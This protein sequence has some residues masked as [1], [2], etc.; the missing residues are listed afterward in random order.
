MAEALKLT[1]AFG[2]NKD[3]PLAVINLCDGSKRCIF[4]ASGNTGVVFDYA[5]GHQVLLRGHRNPISCI[6]AS[7]DRRWLVTADSGKDSL[8]I[9]WDAASGIAVKTISNP[10]VRGVAAVDIS[11]D[12]MLLATLSVELPQV[13][14]VWEW[15]LDN[16]RPLSHSTRIPS[17]DTQISLRFHPGD[18]RHILTNGSKRVFFWSIA[19][20][21]R[22]LSFFSPP[23]STR[24]FKQSVGR[25]T[26]SV[27]V[28]KTDCAVTGTTEGDL[29]L[30]DRIEKKAIKVVRVHNSTVEVVEVIGKHIVTGGADGLIRF[31]DFNF[32]IMAWFE[33]LNAG[34]VKGISFHAFQ[35]AEA[36]EDPSDVFRMR[37]YS[38]DFIVNTD[39][40]LV[41]D[42]ESSLFEE[43]DP[44]KRRGV[45][46]L[47]GQ[48]T[49]VSSLS[50]HPELPVLAVGSVAGQLHLWNYAVKKLLLV[51]IFQRM[52]IC[53]LAYDQVEG[54]YLVVAFD[55]GMI[56]ILDGNTLEELITFEHSRS[57]IRDIVF[58]RDATYFATSDDEHCVGIYKW[59]HRDE[60]PSKPIEWTF[61]GRYK[62]HLKRISGLAFG[63][64]HHLI[65]CAEDRRLVEYSVDTS[66]MRE[67]V[68]LQSAQKIE[69]SL[70]PTAMF[71]DDVEGKLIFATDQGK[72]RLYNAQ[73]LVCEKTVLAPSFGPGQ[74]HFIRHLGVHGPESNRYVAYAMKENVI[75]ICKL[76]LDGNPYKSM[77]VIAHPGPIH[78]LS[79]S[80]DGRFAFSTGGKDSSVLM[81]TVQAGKLDEFERHHGTSGKAGSKVEPYLSLIPGGADSFIYKDFTDYFY[82]AQIRTQGEA[83]TSPRKIVGYIPFE[84]V[85]NVM[86]AVGFF[87]SERAVLDMYNELERSPDLARPGW[88]DFDTSFLLYVNHRP[89]RGITSSDI[90]RAFKVVGAQVQD[91]ALPRPVF[92]DVMRHRGEPV[93]GEEM[94]Q[95]VLSL[96]GTTEGEQ[97]LPLQLTVRYLAGELLQF[98]DFVEDA[99]AGTGAGVDENADPSLS[100]A[101]RQDGDIDDND[102]DDLSVAFTD[103]TISGEA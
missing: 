35:D 70:I 47:Q 33:D 3:L 36:E 31:Y 57:R 12:S 45:L 101:N 9:V 100:N 87:P 37:F 24:E 86:R 88:V 94:S 78:N 66:S 96:L 43:V 103:G 19:D 15:T 5:A 73:D 48:D 44:E 6:A 32:H 22:S 49:E 7:T 82:Y 52:R 29:I 89:P 8:L 92:M 74:I 58:S 18:S 72:F 91:E 98:Q 67:G 17:N 27:F 99:E 4:F 90:C 28:P 61:I 11:P 64:G 63:N 1:H 16:E 25:F 50:T 53:C 34:P 69:Q 62:T 77:G 56:K 97:A 80:S 10:H 65:S 60:N 30:W 38:P 75:G 46:I 102:D 85:P 95:C 71:Y 76:P 84:Q 51:S 41:L 13:F 23:S 21:D 14:S 42:V 40:A 93:S 55:T 54:K 68:K 2:Y 79:V 83:T 81:W 20:D 39:R 59:G 26:K